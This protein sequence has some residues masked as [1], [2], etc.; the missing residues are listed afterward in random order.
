MTT[1]SSIRE[2][3][4]RRGDLPATRVSIRRAPHVNEAGRPE[5]HRQD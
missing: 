3:A 2:K 1:S 4:R 5:R